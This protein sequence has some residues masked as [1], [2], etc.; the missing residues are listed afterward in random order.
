MRK[1]DGLKICWNNPGSVM[2]SLIWVLTELVSPLSFSTPSFYFMNSG[3]IPNSNCYNILQSKW[4][5][6]RESLCSLL[7]YFLLSQVFD[8]LTFQ[9]LL[10]TLSSFFFRTLVPLKCGFGN[11]DYFIIHL[12][13]IIIL[14]LM[15]FLSY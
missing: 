13:I 10:N 4:P 3:R 1:R 5:C 15:L 2:D 14:K 12:Y 7:N 9:I 6:I 8:L 11:A